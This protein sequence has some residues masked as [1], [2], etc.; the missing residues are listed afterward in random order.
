M[1]KTKSTGCKYYYSCK[2]SD[3]IICFNIYHLIFCFINLNHYTTA[4]LLRLGVPSQRLNR[5]KMNK[6]E[7]INSN[8]FDR[9][10][11]CAYNLCEFTQWIMRVLPELHHVGS[12][13]HKHCSLH[14]TIHQ[15]QV[16]LLKGH[17]SLHLSGILL[18]QHRLEHYHICCSWVLQT[19]IITKYGVVFHCI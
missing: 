8:R 17:M 5:T 2:D 6:L 11:H 12:T 18:H 7:W 19:F 16:C 14:T 1:V 3:C 10:W 15:W 13:A 4:V 9:N